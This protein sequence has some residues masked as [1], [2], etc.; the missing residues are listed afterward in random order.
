MLTKKKLF[1]FTFLF[2]TLLLSAR[3]EIKLNHCTVCWIHGDDKLNFCPYQEHCNFFNVAQR[4]I[5]R[6]EDED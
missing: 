2:W 5:S 1:K 4:V 3:R 6:E